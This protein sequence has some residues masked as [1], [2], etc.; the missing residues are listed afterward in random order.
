M[1]RVWIS[2]VLFKNYAQSYALTNNKRELVQA[3]VPQRVECKV[4]H[5]FL[6]LE[7]SERCRK[8]LGC[9]FFFE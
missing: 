4:H 2:G 5:Q 8:G 7:S 3:L 9:K 6:L 1:K